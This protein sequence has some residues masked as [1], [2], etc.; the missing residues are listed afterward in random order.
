MYERANKIRS[1]RTSDIW[2]DFTSLIQN[3]VT[4]DTLVHNRQ[5]DEQNP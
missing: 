5:Q 2:S 3:D 4:W 1:R